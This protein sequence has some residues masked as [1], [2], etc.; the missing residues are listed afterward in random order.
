MYWKPAAFVGIGLLLAAPGEV[1]NQIL[2]RHNLVAFR[3]AM[4]SYAV[5]LLIGFFVGALLRRACHGRWYGTLAFYLLFGTLGLMVEWFL[6]GNAPVLDPFQVVVQPGMFTYWGTMMLGPL[7]VLE[8]V[9]PPGLRRSFL[10]YFAAVSATYLV[11]A[12]V[13][14]RDRGG[15]F[16]GFVIFAAGTAGLN[17]FYGKYFWRL[18]RSRQAPD[19]D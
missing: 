15:I 14:P 8:P 19:V 18:A 17:V 3:Q 2:A 11:V 5:L 9:D 12:T 1:L 4:I 16:F 10:V 6:L 7:F 13:V